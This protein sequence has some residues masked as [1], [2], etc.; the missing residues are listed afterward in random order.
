MKILIVDDS[1]LV[2][3]ILKDYL[4][5]AGFK[6]YAAANFKEAE[7]MFALFHPQIIIKDLYMKGWNV[8]ESIK[9][10]REL[11]SKVK[12]VICSTISSKPM[13]IEGLK[14]GANDFL[15]KPLVRGH[16]LE[17]VNKLIAS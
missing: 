12:I 10:F 16:V 3:L 4:K 17:L 9:F 6:V 13:I 2:R 7:I 8:I 1:P 14:A 5:E 15:L 11:D